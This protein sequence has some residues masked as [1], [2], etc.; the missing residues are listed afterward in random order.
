MYH[1]TALVTLLAIAFYMFTCINV[2][3][4]RTRTGVKVPAMSGHPDFERAFRI[5]ANTLEWMPVFLPALWL[6]AIYIGDAIAAGIG[7]V[8]IIG[9][10]VYFIGYSQAAAKRG[11]GFAIQGIA[12][13][14]LWAGAL[15]A[16]VLRMV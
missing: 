12:A 9:R 14:A 15:A 10:I 11:P 3:R 13:I 1:L 8:W 2:S 7:A 16:V 5:Q 6:F 4:A